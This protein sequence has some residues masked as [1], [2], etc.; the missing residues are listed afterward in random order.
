[1]TSGWWNKLARAGKAHI[2]RKMM[3][4]NPDGYVEILGKFSRECPPVGRGKVSKQF[5]LGVSENS[6]PY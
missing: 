6:G 2:L 5:D 4:E 1:M 3:V